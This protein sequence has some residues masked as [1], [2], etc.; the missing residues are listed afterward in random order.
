MVS[1]LNLA[2]G[3]NNN[4]SKDDS[5]MKRVGNLWQQIITFEN[6]LYA[7]RN[8]QKGKRYR[9]NVLKFN[10][11]LENELL[12]LQSELTSKTY[13]PGAYRTFEIF[14]PKLRLIS[15]AP[16]RDRVVHHALCDWIIPVFENTFIDDS[17][18]NRLGY[19]TH[20]A[21][22][23]FTHFAR[24]TRYVLQ[25]DIRKYFPSIDHEIL[26]CLIR[27]KLKCRD[28][29][30]L[31]DTVIDHSNFQKPVVNHFPGDDLLDPLAR[32]QGL[33]IGNLTSQFFANVYLNGFDHFVKET[34]KYKKYLRYVD[35]F[36]LFSDDRDDLVFARREIEAYLSKFTLKVHPIKS[37][38][39]AT[40]HGVSFLGLRIFPEYIRIQNANIQR[41]RKRLRKLQKAYA[42]GEIS[43]KMVDQSVKSWVSHLEHADTW[44]LRQKIFAD[45]V[46]SRQ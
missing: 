14:E 27:R 33:P 44:H 10:D 12:Q 30:W 17:Y 22:R 13:T 18:A 8:A 37:Q 41:G 38:I 19:G 36:A 11:N 39:V 42:H 29:L 40:E 43:A 16:Y 46:F 31:I 32:R 9:E 34:L 45:L 26:K 35:D 23:R 6:L 7:S 2:A 5:F 28:T 20:R 15:A 21:I 1:G 4:V 3:L 25:C 24:S